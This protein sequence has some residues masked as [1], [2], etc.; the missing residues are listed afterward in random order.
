MTFREATALAAAA[1]TLGSGVSTP[2]KDHGAKPFTYV[3]PIRHAWR[4]ANPRAGFPNR[5]ER[6]RWQSA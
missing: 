5:L 4:T 1:Q 2:A 3:D 6:W